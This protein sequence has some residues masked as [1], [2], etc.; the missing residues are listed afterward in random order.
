MPSFARFVT[1]L[2][3]PSILPDPTTG[4]RQLVVDDDIPP[5]TGLDTGHDAVLAF[6]VIGGGVVGL[7]MAFNGQQILEYDF[8]PP[9]SD[10]T[11]RGWH[12][13]IRG[14]ILNQPDPNNPEQSTNKLVIDA[15]F[16]GKLTLSDFVLTYHASG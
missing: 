3:E 7:K 4:A 1:F 11:P 13:T 6:N 15:E 10:P 12:E 5:L 8:S 16:F 9:H 14:N 2:D